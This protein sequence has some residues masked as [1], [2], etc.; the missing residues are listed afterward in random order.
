MAPVR[1]DERIE[2]IAKKAS[3]VETRRRLVE[4][5]DTSNLERIDAEIKKIHGALGDSTKKLPALTGGLEL[6]RK[7]LA[8]ASQ[9][10]I[11][12]FDSWESFIDNL[13]SKIGAKISSQITNAI[14]FSGTLANGLK[15]FDDVAKTIGIKTERG[16]VNISTNEK[17]RSSP[18]NKVGIDAQEAKRIAQMLIQSIRPATSLSKKIGALMGH[19]LPYI[20]EKQLARELLGLSY[21]ELVAIGARAK[22]LA[23][24]ID[25]NLNAVIDTQRQHA[26]PAAKQEKGQAQQP[27]SQDRLRSTFKATFQ[28][29]TDEEKK[30]PDVI[31]DR[32][33]DTWS[34]A[35]QS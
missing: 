24:P 14:G 16:R 1:T 6:A 25:K 30:D 13:T 20:N 5:L 9:S 34:K 27:R 2:L 3:L 17:L 4:Q 21:N 18:L 32:F 31:I 7:E 8:V 35:K 15:R 28:S 10:I 19:T 33:I 11:D 12:K 22:S 26:S 23:V 29:L